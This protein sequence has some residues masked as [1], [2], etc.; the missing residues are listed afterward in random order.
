MK[1]LTITEK[2]IAEI[3]CPE[4]VE[5]T[6]HLAMSSS[7]C[8]RY[9]RDDFLRFRAQFPG[10]HLIVSES[11]TENMFDML[12]KNEA[13]LVFTLDSHIYNSEYMICAEREEAV[14]FIAAADH[15]ILWSAEES[16]YLKFYIFQVVDEK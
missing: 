2:M 12:Q 8:S 14:H 1:G 3:K 11:G 10:V 15:P 7:V 9:F 16:Y 4:K 5:G 6:I 13:D